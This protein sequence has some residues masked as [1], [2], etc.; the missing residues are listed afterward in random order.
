MTTLDVVIPVH[1][2]ERDLPRCVDRL[3]FDTDL[4]RVPA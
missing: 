4:G 3:L 2:E 1:N